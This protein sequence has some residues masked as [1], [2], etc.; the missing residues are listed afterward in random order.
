MPMVSPV[1]VFRAF[2]E[3]ERERERRRLKSVAPGISIVETKSRYL[4]VRIICVCGYMQSLLFYKQKTKKI[5][6]Y[7]RSLNPFVIALVLRWPPSPWWGCAECKPTE[8]MH[9]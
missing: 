8:R 7:N 5:G 2:W 3:R 6:S 1:E 9:S 4:S